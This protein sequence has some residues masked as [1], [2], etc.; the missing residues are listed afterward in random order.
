MHNKFPDLPL[1]AI[2]SFFSFFLHIICFSLYVCFIFYLFAPKKGLSCETT[3][4]SICDFIFYALFTYCTVRHIKGL[5]PIR[6]SNL[7]RHRKT[8]RSYGECR[9]KTMVCLVAL[10]N[11]TITDILL[12]YRIG[13]VYINFR[14]PRS[15]YCDFKTYISA[16]NVD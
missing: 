13:L 8:Y 16:V 15:A 11:T 4:C 1:L 14:P 10:T 2:P 12:S 6:F 5:F 9:F 3:I 7:L